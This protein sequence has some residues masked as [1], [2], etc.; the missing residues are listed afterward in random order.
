MNCSSQSNT[1][2]RSGGFTLVEVL[3][4]MLFMAIVIPVVVEGISIAGRAGVAAE[5]RREAAQLGDEKL[6]EKVITGEWQDGN[7]AG[8]FGEDHPGFRWELDTSDWD[9]DTMKVVT[10]DVIYTVQGVESTER[11]TTLVSE[12]TTTSAAP[13]ATP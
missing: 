1:R 2:G 13:S 4:A 9:Q 8:D 12:P 5:R 7:Q 3:A 10:L 11:L 6:T